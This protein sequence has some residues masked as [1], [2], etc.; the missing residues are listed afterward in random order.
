M[1]IKK[2]TPI[3]NQTNERKKEERVP[4]RRSFHEVM[5]TRKTHHKP[6]KRR[7]IFDMASKG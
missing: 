7:S 6:E 1:E 5:A 2:D 3:S 4:P